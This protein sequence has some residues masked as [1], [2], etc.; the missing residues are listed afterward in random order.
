MSIDLAPYEQ[1]L[2]LAARQRGYFSAK[3]AAELGV[4]YRTIDYWRGKRR[5]EQVERGVYRLA[6]YFSEGFLDDVWPLWLA[7]GVDAV[8]SHE[9]ALLLHNLS[10]LFPSGVHLTVDRTHRGR[11]YCAGVRAHTTATPFPDEDVAYV[12]GIPVTAVERT[13]IDCV[14]DHVQLDQI[15]LALEQ[16]I[17][18][19]MTTRERLLEKALERSQ[20]C[21]KKLSKLVAVPA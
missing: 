8:V 6:G 2:G 3:Q 1:L 16:A 10:D 21:A 7:S 18:R 12:Q 4:S 20:A 11:H 13:L 19:G 9:S 17:D 5:F 14:T 15:E